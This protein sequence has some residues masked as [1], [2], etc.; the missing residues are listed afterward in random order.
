[1]EFARPQTAD[2]RDHHGEEG[3]G[4]DVERHTEKQIGAAL[5]KLA[6]QL[7]IVNV[8]LEKNV[9]R[10]QRHLLQ[11]R[12]VPSAHDQAPALRVPLDFG[13]HIID[14]VDDSAFG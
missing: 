10:G 1:N 6:A 4:C 12:D 8:K 14:L 2:L 7:A 11:F 9:A 3:I 5:V 13:N